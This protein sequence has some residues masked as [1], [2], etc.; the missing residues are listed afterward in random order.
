MSWPTMFSVARQPAN[1]CCSHPHASLLPYLHAKVIFTLWLLHNFPPPGP[2]AT[3][4]MFALNVI[5]KL[6]LLSL[7]QSDE[8]RR[9]FVQ[10]NIHYKLM[11]VVGGIF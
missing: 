5:T 8:I 4:S 7:L 1:S 2:A 3:T 10:L 11:H 9:V 6:C